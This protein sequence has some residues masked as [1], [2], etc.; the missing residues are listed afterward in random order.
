[1]NGENTAA[2]HAE[3]MDACVAAEMPPSCASA[4]SARGEA[5]VVGS[6]GPSGAPRVLPDPAIC[7]T[8]NIGLARYADCLVEN[9]WQCAHA[10]SFGF[11]HVC[12]HP[13]WWMLAGGGIS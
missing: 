1:M 8:R 11:G 9:P 6:R 4:T 10:M 5:P 7:R 2:R 3:G 13:Q 12:Q